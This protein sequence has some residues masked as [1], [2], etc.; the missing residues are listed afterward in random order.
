MTK[1]LA[2]VPP[3][4]SR[5]SAKLRRAIELRVTE[6]R[7]IA[8]ACSSAGMSTQGY[9]KAMKR[10]AVRDHLE[11]VQRRFVV[12]AEANR[13][14]IKA[15]A[16]R[17]ALD[18]MLNAKSESIRARMAEFLASDG[19]VPQV[20]VSIDARQGGAYEYRRPEQKVVEIEQEPVN[21]EQE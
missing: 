15:Q 10:P 5:L 3:R 8:E 12:E 20:S 13:G 14:L 17:V 11:E 18:L 2:L 4:Q 7:T 21:P 9:H 19:K 6:G 1:P 16:L